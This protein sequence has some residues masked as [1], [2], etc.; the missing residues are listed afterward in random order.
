MATGDGGNAPGTLD[1]AEFRG[2]VELDTGVDDDAEGTLT[3]LVTAAVV[4]AVIVTGGSGGAAG[5]SGLIN[6]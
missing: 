1:G 5:A 2:V 6:G 3:G 4:G